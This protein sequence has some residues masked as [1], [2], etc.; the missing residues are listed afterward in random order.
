M[1][2]D[3]VV[4]GAGPAGL[5]AARKI[6]KKGFSVLTLERDKDFGTRACAEAVSSTAFETAE[7]P[8]Y[9][10]LISNEIKGAY[11]YPPDES[12]SVKIAG[13]TYSGYIL[14]KPIFLSALAREAVAAGSE[15]MMRSEVKS[16]SMTDGKAKKLT[17]EHKGELHDVSFKILVGTDGVG[18]IVSRSCGFDTEGF[19]IIP[20]M[21]YVIINCNIPEGNMIRIFMGNE[22]APLGYAW[23]F[24]KNIFYFPGVNILATADD[25]IF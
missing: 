7:I 21:Q 18:S 19:E 23:V 13:S 15:L 14:N 24:A 11:V 16:I 9:R 10:S 3:A 1:E 8:P 5:L 22:V 17:F 25:H 6:A 20:T 12:K 4:V 2:Y